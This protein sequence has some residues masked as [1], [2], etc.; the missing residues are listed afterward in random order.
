VL[1][2]RSYPQLKATFEQYRTQT[3]KGILDTI[4][5]EMS[6]ALEE[7]FSAI[8][9]FAWDPI[10]FY[11]ERLYKSM[12]GAGTNDAQLIRVMVTRSEV[13]LKLIS[14]AFHKQYGKFLADFI[15]DDCAGDYRRLLLGI[16]GNN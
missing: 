12:K 10:W 13:D 2:T 9:N 5:R 14:Q 7:G 15:K 8:V 1:C 6:G 11:A 3:G 4:K 16:L